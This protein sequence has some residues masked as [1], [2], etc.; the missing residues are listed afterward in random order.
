[1]AELNLSRHRARGVPA[2]QCAGITWAGAGNGV[3]AKQTILEERDE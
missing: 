3:S 2:L 1:M